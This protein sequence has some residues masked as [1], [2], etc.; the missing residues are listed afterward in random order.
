MRLTHV[1]FA[2]CLSVEWAALESRSVLRSIRKCM[3]ESYTCICSFFFFFS[4][5]VLPCGGG[6]APFSPGEFHVIAGYQKNGEERML[7]LC[8]K[9][10]SLSVSLVGQIRPV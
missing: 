1:G 2:R 5:D 9:A 8:F 6:A 3:H 10:A 4:K 7:Q